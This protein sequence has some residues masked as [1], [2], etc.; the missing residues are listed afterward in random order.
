MHI[1]KTNIIIKFYLFISAILIILPLSEFGSLSG[2]LDDG[3]LEA[4]LVFVLATLLITFY[5]MHAFNLFR[6]IEYVTYDRVFSKRTMVLISIASFIWFLFFVI[7]EIDLIVDIPVFAERYRNGYY[8]GSGINTYPILIVVPS[9]L[10][11]I[12]LKQ[13]RLDIGF[14]LPFFLIFISSA[15]V[16]L[17]I[18]LF[19]IVIL[20]FIR[21]FINQKVVK[22]ISFFFLFFLFLI[23]YKYV[24]NSTVS[25]MSFLEVMSYILGRLDFKTL[26]E[27]NGF[28]IGFEHLKYFFDFSSMVYFKEIFVSFNNDLFYGKPTLSLYSG[29]ALPISVVL[30]NT[31]YIFM[32]P[33]LLLYL[34]MM[35]K[36]LRLLI[37]SKSLI[38]SSI[39]INIFIVSLLLILEDIG[40]ITKIPILLAVSIIMISILK[41]NK[42]KFIKLLGN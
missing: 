1:F 36:L 42:I 25:E 39:Y 28:E 2:P 31:M 23:S 8:K 40:G 24:L 30:Y 38:I 16:G 21:M 11:L 35:I 27:F 22:I 7:Q 5:I 13:R 26:L 9:F 19:G 18:F 15:I 10:Y 17:R 12:L 34:M 4:Y 33:F 20:L 14:Y 3:D 29:I 41:I 32:I 37:T 6:S